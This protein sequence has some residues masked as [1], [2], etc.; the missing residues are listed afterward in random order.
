MSSFPL[1]VWKTFRNE[2]AEVANPEEYQPLA[3]DPSTPDPL[4]PEQA[5]GI[6]EQLSKPETRRADLPAEWA[7]YVRPSLIFSLL[8]VLICRRCLPRHVHR[9]SCPVFNWPLTAA[10]TRSSSP[11]RG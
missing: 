8:T 5:M 3:N 4:E 1:K 6:G 9:L 11:Q 7:A 10:C 2:Q